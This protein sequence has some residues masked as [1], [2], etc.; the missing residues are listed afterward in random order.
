MYFSCQVK[1]EGG[2]PKEDLGMLFEEVII[3]SNGRTIE[4]VRNA[5]YIQYFVQNM[6]LSRDTKMKRAEEGFSRIEDDTWAK[7]YRNTPAIAAA[8]GPPVVVASAGDHDFGYHVAALDMTDDAGFQRQQ[9]GDEI[10][11]KMEENLG[12]YRN[13]IRR[14]D[15]GTT[16]G[17]HGDRAND[18]SAKYM[19]MKFR[20]A[21]CGLLNQDKFLPVFAMPLTIQLRLSDPGRASSKGM[22]GYTIQRP[23]MHCQML[24]VS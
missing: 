11:S 21:S 18:V 20:I 1:F 10:A 7:H 14:D 13:Q 17:A 9:V 16:A 22:T 15:Q 19:L 23:R 24:S 12:Y 2:Y 6:G 3:S 4:R 5:Q 8:V